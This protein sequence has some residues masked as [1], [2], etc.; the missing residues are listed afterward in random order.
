MDQSRLNLKMVSIPCRFK[1]N[2]CRMSGEILQV[3][4]KL[5][6]R[7]A[8]SYNVLTCKWPG[9]TTIW[10]NYGPASKTDLAMPLPDLIG[11]NML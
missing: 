4:S 6:P 7:R 8:L 1:K 5:L 9:E 11:P 3:V 2:V 10:T